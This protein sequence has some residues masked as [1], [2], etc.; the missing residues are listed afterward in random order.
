MAVVA[1]PNAGSRACTKRSAAAPLPGWHFRIRRSIAV[2]RCDVTMRTLSDVPATQ[3]A[4]PVRLQRPNTETS[5]VDRFWTSSCNGM[6]GANKRQNYSACSTTTE[7][8]G[9]S[10]ESKSVDQTAGN[11]GNGHYRPPFRFAMGGVPLGN[12]FE[13]VAAVN[14][15]S[16]RIT[17]PCRPRYLRSS[18]QSSKRKT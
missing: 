4:K 9:S 15:K 11:T 6:G 13:Y 16:S 18:G 1:D 3:L 12:E 8:R 17:P 2:R 7:S 14:S 10:M 5:R